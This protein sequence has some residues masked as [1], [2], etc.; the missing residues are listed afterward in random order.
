MFSIRGAHILVCTEESD[1]TWLKIKINTNRVTIGAH[2]LNYIRLHTSNAERLHCKIFADSANSVIIENKSLRNPIHVNGV[3]VE[4]AAK[5]NDKDRFEVAG[6]TF[7]WN[8]N[9][10]HIKVVSKPT[11]HP[12]WRRKTVTMKR[13]RSTGDITKQSFIKV[14]RAVGLMLDEFRKRRTIHR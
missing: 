1:K 14:P 6:S 10:E 9:P 5:L 11:K 3:C 13:I 7:L 12:N 2:P 8:F 4:S